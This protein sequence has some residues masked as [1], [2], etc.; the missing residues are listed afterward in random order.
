MVGALVAAPIADRIGRKF[1]ISFW[2][3]INI[4]GIIVQMATTTKWYQVAMGRWVAGMGVGAL[5]GL[6]PMYMSES[7]PCHVRGAMIR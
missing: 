4:V 7:A 1:S 3:L 5:S 6:V 2:S